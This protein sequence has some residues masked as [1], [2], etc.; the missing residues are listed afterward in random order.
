MTIKHEFIQNSLH[1]ALVIAGVLLIYHIL[2][3]FI[4]RWAHQKKRIIPNLLSRYIYFPGLFFILVIVSWLLLIFLEVDLSVYWYSAIRHLMQIL[5]TGGAAFLLTRAVT[6]AREITLHHYASDEPL[7][8]SLRKAKTKFQLIQRVF[9]FLIVL[10][11]L[12]IVLMTFNNIRQVG[13]TLLASAGVVGLII[14]FAAQKSLGTLFAG[15]QI[16]ISQPIRI[17]D[18]VVVE[19]KSGIISEITLTYV[20]INSWDGRRF[21]IPINYFLEK[22]F[23]NWTRVSP[24]LISK[25]TLQA[26]YSLPVEKLRLVLKQWLEATPLWDKRSWGISV[27]AARENTMEI[28]ATMSAKNADDASGLESLIRE[29]LIN[30]L[31]ENYPGALPVSRLTITNAQAG[32][33]K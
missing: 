12:S 17:D 25:V 7:N 29:K 6:V 10:A 28:M 15:M 23:E 13:A 2:F 31:R 18:L 19:D 11:A 4:K 20:V 9:N 5:L 27:T 30:F 21:I 26:D 24:E 1:A 3:Y 32:I 14:G 16:A 33:R 22:P 8:Y